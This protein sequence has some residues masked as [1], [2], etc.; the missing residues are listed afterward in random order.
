MSI[1]LKMLF[2]ESRAASFRPV[3]TGSRKKAPQQWPHE[4][5]TPE[6]LANAGFYYKPQTDS[7]DNVVCFMCKK[8]LNG[9]VPDDDPIQEHYIHAQECPWAVTCHCRQEALR[10]KKARDNDE[11]VTLDHDVKSDTF[12]EAREKTF[13]N[14]WPHE[15]KKAW[16]GKLKK[17][18]QAG[19]YFTPTPT[20]DDFVCCVYCE[21]GLDGWERQ[22]DP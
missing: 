6:A 7:N 16:V 15:K 19:L 2:F 17:M 12:L 20:S 21:L 11:A 5:P 8:N 22:D 14:M 3:A 1:N 18:A 10:V 4:S 9:W 13:G